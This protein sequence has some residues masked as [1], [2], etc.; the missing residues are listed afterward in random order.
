MRVTVITVNQD[1]AVLVRGTSALGVRG[2]FGCPLVVGDVIFIPS[3]GFEDNLRMGS[4][5]QVDP[6]YESVSDVE[7]IPGDEL[8]ELMEPA[9]EPG[10]YL[11]QGRVAA[12]TGGFTRVSVRGFVFAVDNRDLPECS[13]QIGDGLRFKLQRLHFWDTAR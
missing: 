4:T 8:V 11:I 5:I 3:R 12:T 6:G 2:T 13:L 7:T 9:G 1:E 10:D